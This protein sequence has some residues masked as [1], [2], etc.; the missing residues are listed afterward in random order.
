MVPEPALPGWYS[1]EASGAP[2]REEPTPEDHHRQ[3][4]RR[5]GVVNTITVR[6]RTAR[7]TLL[8]LTLGHSAADLSSGALWALLPF[9]VAERHYSYAAVGAFAL[10]ASVAS[11]LFQPVVGAHGDRREAWLLLPAGLIVAGLGIAAV[12]FTTAYSATLIAVIVCS[13]GVAAYHP[14]GARWARHASG[15]RVTADMS[16][17]SVG[18]GVGWALGPLVVAAV[19]AP[20]GLHGTALIAI[21]PFAAAAA[22]ALVVR[23]L[24]G[25]TPHE[26]RGAT[27][28]VA[29]ACEWRPFGGLLALFALSSGVTTGVL[30]FLPLYLL[31]ERGASPAASNVMSSILLAAGACGTLLGGIAAAHRLGRRWVLIVPQ[32]ALVPAIAVLPSLSYAAM[33]PAV[34]VTGVAM[35]ANMSV[36]LVLGQEYMPSRMGLST[37]LIVGL[38]GGAGGLIVAAL[39]VLGDAAG[40]GPV[41]YVLAAL[42]LAVAGIA[43][44]LPRPAAAPMGTIWSRRLEAG[45]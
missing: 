4:R 6:Q 22:V 9:L 28:A 32:L 43:S 8:T 10:T 7:G 37:G 35:N 42:P 5:R 12:G 38:C 3:A 34:I 19:L 39:G 24:D 25:G 41:L 2:D 33:I 15:S 13:A 45:R 36:A 21:I 26:Q 44:L 11:A 40:L 29:P 31:G 14:E 1:P 30:T 27:S 20:L 18:G 16:V 23:R 17:Y